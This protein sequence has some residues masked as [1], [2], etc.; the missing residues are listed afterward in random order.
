MIR[1][2]VIAVVVAAAG[3]ASAEE[4]RKI[5]LGFDH[6]VHDRNLVVSGGESIA[7]GRC[8][9]ESKGKLVGKPGH[10]A[11][12]GA[13]HGPAPIRPR[14]GA[15]VS[16]A[17]RAKV[18]TSCH[19]EALEG[20]PFTG[21]L[22]VGYPPYENDPDFNITF[23]H[24][25]HASAA[26]TQCHDMRPGA[27]RPATHQR[28][29]GC[30]DGSGAQGRGPAMA[31]CTSCHPRAVGKPQP[32]ELAALRDTVGA[33]F[34]HTRHAGRSAGGKDCAGCHAD[35]RA[36]DDIELPRPTAANCATSGCH[37]GKAAFATTVACTKCHDTAPER[38]EV[39][40]R[41]ERFSHGGV[42][43]DVVEART[44]NACHPISATGEVQVTGH[45]ACVDCHAD[46]FGARHPKTCSACHNATE[47]WRPLVADRALPERTEFGAMLDHDKHKSTACIAC[48]KLRTAVAELR[49]PRG[50]SSCMGSGCH[51]P[52][53]GPAPRFETCSGCH[54]MGLAAEREAARTEAPWSV[55]R[56][57]AHATHERTPDQKDLA[58][59]ACHAQLSGSLL[60]L[61]T[62]RKAACLPCHDDKQSAFK[63]TGTTCSR[64]H[65]GAP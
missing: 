42:H 65:A 40:R 37:D 61:P 51:A 26:C 25:Q 6:I 19:A 12:F 16:F 55:R 20:R 35:I 36:T 54:R 11:C 38:F 3:T 5:A 18:C 34:S 21:K 28:C 10:A 58:C 43:A 46:D 27:A 15:K 1:A 8:H 33:T 63:L 60:E 41:T 62:P 24:K 31:R 47:P 45:A 29:L 14:R 17:D 50:H 13:C 59:T 64:C 53:A 49:P 23:G 4:R 2:L 56:A 9:A 22:A 48:H 32:P 39:W 52:K 44:C 57:F 30:H 7:C